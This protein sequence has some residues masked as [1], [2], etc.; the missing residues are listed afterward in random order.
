M[1]QTYFAKYFHIWTKSVNLSY[2]GQMIARYFYGISDY[3]FD[4][5]VIKAFKITAKLNDAAFYPTTVVCWCF[6]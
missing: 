1:S 4:K 5:F 2:Y 3:K 6:S